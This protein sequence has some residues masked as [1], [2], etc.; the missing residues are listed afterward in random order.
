MIVID[1]NKVEDEDKQINAE[2]INESYLVGKA[3]IPNL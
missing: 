3:D 1:Y 2:I